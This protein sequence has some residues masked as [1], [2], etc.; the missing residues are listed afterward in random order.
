MTKL[1]SFDIPFD[2]YQAT[3][4]IG[5]G[6]AGIVYGVTNSSGENFA[7]KSLAPGR[8]TQNDLRGSRMRSPSAND[9]TIGT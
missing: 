9:R 3:E 8:V 2:A 5:E 7:L 6:G 1:P 4:I